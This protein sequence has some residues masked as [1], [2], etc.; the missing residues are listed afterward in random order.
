MIRIDPARLSPPGRPDAARGDAGASRLVFVLL[1]S[2]LLMAVLVILAMALLTR[3]NLNQ[4]TAERD[5]RLVNNA[6]SHNLEDQKGDLTSVTIWD[7]AIDKLHNRRDLAWLDVNVG[8]WFYNNYGHHASLA[9]AGNGMLLRGWI[10]G[11]PVA[12]SEAA[13]WLEA[14]RSIWAGLP[15]RLAASPRGEIGSEIAE[16]GLIIVEGKTYFVTAGVVLPDG[17]RV[18]AV[19]GPRSMIVSVRSLDDAWL[20]ENADHFMLANL[21]FVQTVGIKEQSVAPVI[22]RDG[23]RA[24]FLVWESA[25][26]GDEFLR[27]MLLPAGIGLVAL[28]G[29][30]AVLASI[31]HRA[32]SNLIASERRMRQ[33]AFEDSLTGLPN[34]AALLSAEAPAHGDN[35]PVK[36][37]L[38]I[39]LDRFKE[40][41]DTLGHPVGDQLIVEVG[42]RMRALAATADTV[43]R[44]G[45]DEFA[46]LVRS[47]RTGSGIETL[48]STIITALSEPFYLA[49]TEQHLSA[50]IGICL[51]DGTGE[52]QEYLRRADV[53]LYRAKELGRARAVLFDAKFDIE[54]QMRKRLEGDFRQALAGG[55]LSLAYQPQFAIASMGMTGVE[56]LVRW[57]H[58]ERGYIS[59]LVFVPIAEET[60]LIREMGRQVL[61]QAMQQALHWP[62][63]TVAVNVSTLQ[64]R[65]SGF[66]AMLQELLD[67]IPVAPERIELELTESVLLEQSDEIART[68]A[69]V[70]A[71]GFRLA[72]DDFGTGFS[73]LRYLSRYQ[74]DKIKI[75]RGFIVD[76]HLTMR[77]MGI[78]RSVAAIGHVTG[79]KICAEGVETRE[80]FTMVSEIGCTEVQGFFFM[81]PQPAEEID[82]LLGVPLPEDHGARPGAGQQALRPGQRLSIAQPPS[83]GTRKA[84]SR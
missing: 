26:P 12:D 9:L 18:A 2:G 66:C 1:T 38:L 14:T 47:A 52:Q 83:T 42:R 35:A 73:S 37:T 49:G 5:I 22:A 44:L 16:A 3:A 40:V 23:K 69:S 79:L 82:A 81:R 74:F 24:G 80:Q 67:E 7:E 45:G 33:M 78:L 57:R 64:V 8:Q 55:Q 21:R 61:R 56:A 48:A 11:E 34:R 62:A 30:T 54:A 70:K 15:G 4:L 20:A 53:A 58:P 32:N 68:L 77:A 19:P 51:H 36:A 50:S 43:G 60:G 75:D 59:P 39:D 29:L 10:G 76:A 72:L 13:I 25:K 71:L 6:L 63:L 46:V 41:N 28:A 31:G 27:Q 65:D 84:H 17:G